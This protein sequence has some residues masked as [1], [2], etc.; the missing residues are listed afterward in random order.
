VLLEGLSGLGQGYQHDEG[1]T[2]E[3]HF[4]GLFLDCED[5]LKLKCTTKS[6]SKASNEGINEAMLLDESINRSYR[7]AMTM[8]KMGEVMMG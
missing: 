1:T 6:L 5:V 8:M 7:M 2:K 4:E 3:L